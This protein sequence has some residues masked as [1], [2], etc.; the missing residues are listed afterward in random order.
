MISTDTFD[1][2]GECEVILERAKATIQ[3]QM[4]YQGVNATGNTSRS[5]R[6]ERYDG[7]VRLVMG[8]TDYPT[9]PLQTL[10]VGRPGG[11]VPRGFTDILTEWSRAKG[12]QFPT[13]SRRRSFA[14]LLGRRIQREGTLRHS[15]P[16]DVY[17]SIITDAANSIEADIVNSITIHLHN[18]STLQ[19]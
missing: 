9:A 8:G 12:L 13:E 11:P 15:N 6:V 16:V 2:L 14:Y 17:S 18:P 19:Q 7:G 3:A 4:E 5:F 10:E 1:I